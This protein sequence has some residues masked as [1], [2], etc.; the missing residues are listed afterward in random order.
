VAT[1]MPRPLSNLL[2]KS[3]SSYPDFD[4]IVI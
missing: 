1:M 2:E 3:F 4:Y